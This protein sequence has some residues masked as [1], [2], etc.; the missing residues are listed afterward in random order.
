MNAAAAASTDG[1]SLVASYLSSGGFLDCV[2]QDVL[3]PAPASVSTDAAAS[4]P[5][6]TPHSNSA[7]TSASNSATQSDQSC[8]LSAA[9]CSSLPSP[10][11]KS[12]STSSTVRSL[13]ESLSGFVDLPPPPPPP[14]PASP[15]PAAESARCHHRTGDL[16][17]SLP[18]GAERRPSNS[19]KIRLP[20]PPR[21]RNVSI[22]ATSAASSLPAHPQT[23]RI[24]KP[25]S[26]ASPMTRTSTAFLKKFTQ[27]Q[28]NAEFL[29]SVPLHDLA[30]QLFLLEY[31]V[32]TF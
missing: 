13:I 27:L 12:S 3:L 21:G 22:S 9:N 16:S 10:S 18:S 24:S 6:S 30:D 31:Q 11:L 25:F 23:V 32:H 29:L 14:L 20:P 2:N 7:K 19:Q 28:S 1:Q 17:N 26:I 4:R 15:A 5:I 8:Y